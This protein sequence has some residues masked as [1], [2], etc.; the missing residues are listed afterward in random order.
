MKQILEYYQS[1]P[2]TRLSEGIQDGDGPPYWVAWI[3]EL[4]GCKTDG[5]TLV[6]AM[7]NLDVV[8]DDYIQAMLEFG[9]DISLPK[10]I[11]ETSG[12]IE[13]VKVEQDP[14][15]KFVIEGDVDV[16]A[17]NASTQNLRLRV[18]EDTNE[19]VS[20]EKITETR[21]NLAMSAG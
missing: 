7:A 4:S 15:L 8:F 20:D 21:A 6:D 16:T 17:E 2:Y 1:L 19:W 9:S 10:Q 5:A 18:E 11:K 13:T 3:N 12:M 14:D